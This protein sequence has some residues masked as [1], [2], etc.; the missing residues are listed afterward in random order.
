MRVINAVP[1]VQATVAGVTEK[2]APNCILPALTTI[3]PLAGSDVLNFD[4]SRGFRLSA[5]TSDP[6]VGTPEQLLVAP[7]HSRYTLVV[8]PAA[9][10]TPGNGSISLIVVTD[11]AGDTGAL[12]PVL[13]AAIF[14]VGLA[15]MHRLLAIALTRIG[16]VS[17][18]D[19]SAPSQQRGC[20]G[21]L[22]GAAQELARWLVRFF[23]YSSLVMPTAARRKHEK[24]AFQAVSAAVVNA[25]RGDDA[26]VSLS[27][28][29]LADAQKG[30]HDGG[31]DLPP[32]AI[33][34]TPMAQSESDGQP[35]LV[36]EDLAGAPPAA[37]ETTTVTSASSSTRPGSAGR[38]A[39]V[40]AL[41][42]LSLCIMIF[43]NSGGECRRRVASW[44]G[45]H[46][47]TSMR[48]SL[49][50]PHV[51][52]LSPIGGGY[53]FFQHIAWNGL[54]LADVV[55]PL[56]LW[57]QAS[58]KK[59]RV[60]MAVSISPLPL[61]LP[62][63]G[64]S[65]AMSF[66]S[67]RRRGLAVGG[68]VAKVFARAARTWALGLFLNN[69]RTPAT[70]R[71]LGVLPYFAFSYAIVGLCLLLPEGPTETPAALSA[72]ARA[73]GPAAAAAAAS[74][75][76]AVGRRWRQWA[77]MGAVAVTYLSLR[78]A[79]PAAPG[80]PAG[81][82]GPGGLADGG[83]YLHLACTG[84]AARA[85]DLAVLGYAHMYKSATCSAA[86]RCAPFEP[87]GVMGIAGAAWLSWLGVQA[88]H[89]LLQGRARPL[90]RTVATL[91]AVAAATG[92][93]GGALAGF[94]QEGG[95]YPVNKNLWSPSFVLVIAA[96]GYGS[97]AAGHAAI[98]AWGAWSGAPFTFAGANSI[99]LYVGSSL[100]GGYAP[101]SWRIGPGSHGEM[102]AGNVVGV[103]A[104]LAVA[105]V[106]DLK[107]I[108]VTL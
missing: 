19:S 95:L 94:A 72:A 9:A 73:L 74:L 50:R 7:E 96:L 64:V 70:W 58:R 39:S 22:V 42:G 90:W 57:L 41:R 92:L 87:E 75:W 86:M 44:M 71:L 53:W 108:F 104:W 36:S 2:C 107:R 27:E 14:L 67:A 1:G 24:M 99:L 12:L 40:D 97:L 23:G 4:C 98:D 17:W 31:S 10:P 20:V 15:L 25:G 69:G 106:L 29:L 52:P 32:G 77:V 103:L 46:G 101:F 66:A 21:S 30:E 62:L 13:W 18:L 56:F 65:M 60:R 78:A 43:V 33:A 16:P 59:S 102:L 54:T 88:G 6:R 3:S 76:T 105:R 49:P 100:L 28:T 35:P 91:G 55:F 81:Y 5:W 8:A 89:S 34:P 84:G 93:L 48:T 63:Q 83:R 26:E 47:L 51:P 68:L 82:A 79:L 80:C 37:S 61:L 85:V 38:F 45:L 11:A